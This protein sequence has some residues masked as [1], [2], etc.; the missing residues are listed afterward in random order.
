MLVTFDDG[1]DDSAAAIELLREHQIKSTLYVSTGRIDHARGP[2]LADLLSLARWPAEVE[3]GAHTITHPHLDELA[4]EDARRE[5]E[6][7][8][9]ALQDAIGRD[10]L[11]FAYP[12]GM[13][14]AAIRRLVI[15]AGF[16]SAAAVKN[17]LSHPAD[18]P[19]AIARWTVRR[20]TTAQELAAVLAGEAQLA[21]RGERVRTRAYRSARRARRRTVRRPG[22]AEPATAFIDLEAPVAI[23]DVDISAPVDDVLV[24]TAVSGRPYHSVAVLVRSGGRPLGWVAVPDAPEVMP[25]EELSRRIAATLDSDAPIEVATPGPAIGDALLISVVITTCAEPDAVV[26][27]V[28]TIAATADGP[29]EVIVVENR[30]Q[31]SPVR[32]AVEAELSDLP[33]VSVIEESIRGLSSAR[34]AGLLAARGAVVAFIDDDIAVDRG[35]MASVRATFDAHPEAACVTGLILPRELETESQLQLERFAG[36]GKGFVPCAFSLAQP[37]P[38]SPLFPFTAGHF[39]S[40]ANSAFRRSALLALG[41]FDVALGTGTP[42]RGAEDL[43]V[44]IR[45]IQAGHAIVY[46]PRAITWHRHPDSPGE[47]EQRAFSYGFGLGALIAKLV[48]GPSRGP[49]LR[50]APA[51]IAYL[52]NPR[53]RKNAGR[54]PEFPPR[55]KRLELLGLLNGPL[56]YYR[57]RRQPRGQDAAE[58][59]SAA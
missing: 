54:G 11:T 7:S 27:C 33:N 50:R 13:H 40:G 31:H 19:W 35:W 21:W 32:A 23:R 12:H 48:F 49:I 10:V 8:R 14:S 42:A 26:E 5:I 55:L 47:L 34:N 51:A 59:G 3:L 46:E 56:G 58:T 2:T 22:S 20:T 57:S 18:D 4:L 30:P 39:G 28:R 41:G 38:D 9:Q 24:G 15:E 16:T 43:D 37:P 25:G 17:A 36:F 52:F 1:Y 53:S 44:Y 45:V 6:G 29:H